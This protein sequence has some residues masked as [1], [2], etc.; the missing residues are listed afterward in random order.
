MTVTPVPL[1]SRGGSVTWFGPVRVPGNL[2][3]V[4]T[5][6]LPAT[7]ALLG[8]TAVS[9]GTR[10]Q[11]GKP[12]PAAAAPRPAPRPSFDPRTGLLEASVASLTAASARGDRAD[13]ARWADRI[14]TARM[15]TLLQRRER[16]TV[17]AALDGTRILEGNVRLL[18]W[19]TR[20]IGDDDQL[21]AERAIQTVGELLRADQLGKLLEWE[22]AAVE[23]GAACAALAR[24]ADQSSV[25]QTLRLRALEA[26]AEGYAFCRV[27][28][29][30]SALNGEMWPEL[31]RASLLAPQIVR[32]KTV[33][34][35][36]EMTAD[37]APQVA[38]AA[39]A[40]WCRHR[41]EPLRRQGVTEEAKR[42]FLRMRA[43]VLQPTITAED[44]AEMLPCLSLSRDPEDRK[45]FESARKRLIN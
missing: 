45:A 38:A 21:V 22:V 30:A 43:L 11:P 29:P 25:A 9:R 41:F 12:R 18:P 7:L 1:E 8:A 17:L 31:R 39:A 40:I 20:L 27:S 42:R 34:Q 2:R 32:V 5:A 35:I 44:A 6:V 13:L 14:G 10:A 19:V 37:R 28:I 16:A 15:A 24:A 4:L 3:R 36:G 33:E 23:V 26:L